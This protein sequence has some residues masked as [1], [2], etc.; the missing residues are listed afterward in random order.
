[1]SRMMLHGLGDCTPEHN[2]GCLN[3]ATHDVPA[4][5]LTERI[6]A[7]LNDSP[8]SRITL[9]VTDVGALLDMVGGE[10]K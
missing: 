1:M 6:R 9:D 3:R 4:P 8:E 5:T 7:A 10:D 2:C